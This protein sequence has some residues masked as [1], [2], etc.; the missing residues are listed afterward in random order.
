M[1]KTPAPKSASPVAVAVCETA[2]DDKF[3]LL[4][5]ALEQAGFWRILEATRKA[6]AA[7]RKNFRILLKPDLEFFDR[8]APTGTDPELVEQLM[9]LLFERGYRKISVG[10]GLSSTD[11]WLENREVMVLAELA[12]YR[13][14]TAH[15]H[16][17]EVVNLSEEVI[18]LKIKQE[19]AL[20]NPGLS[21][22]WV[23]AQFRL[24]FAKNK[25]DEENRYALNLR[26]LLNVLP[27]RE[28]EYHYRHRLNTG[29]VCVAL[30]QHTP[31]H[32]ALIDA[33]VSNH[34]GQGTRVHN[35]LLTRTM[36]ASPNVLLADWAGALKMGMDPYASGL[37][38]HALRTL[39]LPKKYHFLGELAPYAG[40]Q[41]V[42]LLLSDSVQQRNEAFWIDRL[43]RP[44]L[45][46]VNHELFPFKNALDAQINSFLTKFLNDR[47]SRP[48][49][50]GAMIGLNY[51]LAGLQNAVQ[52]WR[53]LYDKDKLRRQQ[54][55]LG[56]DLQAYH[57]QDYEAVID[58]LA[59]LAQIARH[60]PPDRNG[61]RW[62]YLDRSVLFE[63]S[64]LLPVPYHNFVAQV[65]IS[66]AVQMMYDNVG[67]ACVP[68]AFDESRRVQYQAERNIYLPQPN[69]MVLF[70]GKTIDVGK[71]EVIKYETGRQ[72]IF[73]RTVTSAN[74]SADFDDG[75]VTFAQHEGGTLVT[76][77]ARQKFALPLLWQALNLDFLPQLKDLLVSAAYVTFFSRT[78]AN[79]EAVY[80]GR[81]PFIGRHW[82][83]AY[84][85]PG[86][87][88]QHFVAQQLQDLLSVFS[89][90]FE[91]LL[92]QTQSTNGRAG[93]QVD[94]M[95]FRHFSNP[96][97]P[98]D[99]PGKMAKEF[100]TDLSQALQKDLKWIAET[101]DR[102]R[103]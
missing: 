16:P 69:W 97:A 60:T 102:G 44:W 1:K 28:K 62:R 84:G 82:Q 65:E 74:Q 33:F 47:E 70:G 49:A 94:D 13:F 90:L 78:L 46:S 19:H 95:G 103:S 64:R 12:G 32:F 5:V 29:E 40:W 39:G 93:E 35:P 37:N 21:R 9:D 52:A 18:P 43:A 56:I 73:W 7:T 100:F 53:I 2:N 89:G 58:Y 27:L 4:E 24:S 80:E 87:E 91:R 31:V 34:G 99:S 77:V 86:A 17:Y 48:L 63:Y 101:P 22:H 98:P 54:T 71:L 59:P 42:S 83:E 61:L 45:Q 26:N 92:P 8:G 55:A 88:A 10:D 72:T 30:L 51:M 85:E 50:Y 23:E 57:P 68:V 3:S 75:Q 79:Y 38:A 20:L 76:I 96:S 25:T 15:G 41:N 66:K 36:I 6:A 14:V 67:G 11:A 81:D